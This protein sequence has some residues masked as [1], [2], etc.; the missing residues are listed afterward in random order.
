MAILGIYVKFQGVYVYTYIFH[1]I[2]AQV[3][4][5]SM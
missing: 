5:S 2:N 1:V 3:R 4:V